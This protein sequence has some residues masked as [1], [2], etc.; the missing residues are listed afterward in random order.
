LWLVTVAAAF[1]A[2]CGLDC[3][4]QS[5]PHCPSSSGAECVNGAWQCIAHDL[6]GEVAPDFSSPRDLVSASD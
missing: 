4:E 6:S 3:S 1:A 5:I 2:G